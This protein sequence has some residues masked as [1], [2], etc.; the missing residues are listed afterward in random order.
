MT[1][2]PSPSLPLLWWWRC[3]RWRVESEP[4][5]SSLTC[6]GVIG[7]N[8]MDE[9]IEARGDQGPQ[10]Q[11]HCQSQCQ[12]LVFLDCMAML[13]S[14]RGGHEDGPAHM[15]CERRSRKTSGGSLGETG[16]TP[17]YPGRLP[18][19]CFTLKP[20]A[21]CSHISKPPPKTWKF[22][23]SFSLT[24]MPARHIVGA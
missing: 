7:T 24:W 20:N 3:G 22:C 19:N 21:A 17:L 18:L 8:S 5:G 14:P 6:A 9:H 1:V 11:E 2:W 15:K 23:T 12:F 10:V 13:S 4:P 16:V